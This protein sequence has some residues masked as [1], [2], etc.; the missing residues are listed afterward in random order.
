MKHEEALWI[1]GCLFMFHVF[2]YSPIKIAEDRRSRSSAVLLFDT[3]A[4]SCRRW[5]HAADFRRLHSFRAVLVFV[6]DRFP[7][8]KGL[9]ALTLDDGM[10]HEDILSVFVR[11]D[12]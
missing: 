2:T 6:L 9:E 5:G 11:R 4:A 8:L 7:I 1:T 3:S 10:M 12:E